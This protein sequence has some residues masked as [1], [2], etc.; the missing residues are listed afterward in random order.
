M[1]NI[2]EPGAGIVAHVNIQPIAGDLAEIVLLGGAD[3]AVEVNVT[4]IIADKE[5]VIS[6]MV[7]VP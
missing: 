7:N 4:I 2:H 6:I 1:V 5:I 3:I